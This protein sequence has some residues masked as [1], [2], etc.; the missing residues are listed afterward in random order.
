MHRRITAIEPQKKPGSK[1]VNVFLDGSFA[2]SLKEELAAR[3]VTGSLLSDA[4]VAAY[5]QEDDLHRV[6]DA[7][8][9]LLSYRPRSVVELRGRLLRR[10]FEP[11]RVAEALER[12]QAMGVVD[13]AEFA[14]FWVENRQNHRPRGGRLL[15]AELRAKGIDREVIEGVLPDEQ[16]EETSA[17]RVAQ[18]K[19]RSLEGLNWP[20]FRR[21]LGD[22]LVRRGFGYETA[23][24]TV[25]QVWKEL[26]QGEDDD[27]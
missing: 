24:S 13:D 26:H 18:R 3:L 11:T 17:Y 22:H 2:F 5:Q 27:L 14:Q 4:E 15:Q 20:E 7:A 16:E 8:L 23:N 19:A 9:V 10:G 1:R 21:K 6:F 12:L 25:K